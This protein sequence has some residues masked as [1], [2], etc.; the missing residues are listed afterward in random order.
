M[1]FTYP[2][3]AAHENWMHDC[4]SVMTRNALQETNEAVPEV[5]WE[6]CIPD[7][8]KGRLRGRRG[9][10]ERYFSFRTAAIALS[11]A[12]RE[13]AVSMWNTQNLFP[14]LF[15]IQTDCVSCKELPDS[16]NEFIIKTKNL[17]SFGFELLTDLGIRDGQ[18]DLVYDTEHGDICP[19]CGLEFF[20]APKV[21]RPDL[22]HFLAI[23]LY[24]FAGVNLLNLIPMGRDCNRIH[25]R[26]LDVLNCDQGNR[27]PVLNPY[28]ETSLSVSILNS[29]FFAG[30]EETIKPQWEIDVGN[31]AVSSTWNEVWNIKER[32]SASVFTRSYV[33]WLDD[34]GKWCLEANTV[35]GTDEELIDSM[36]RYNRTLEYSGFA[37]RAF[38]RKAFFDLV[39]SLTE[40]PNYRERTFLLLRNTLL[41]FT[42]HLIACDV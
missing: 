4:L 6:D 10:R 25:K 36:D 24:P 1:L 26:A 12:D 42:N 22:D 28:G 32:Y 7:P 21:S 20:E 15:E 34:F 35:T 37:D 14:D 18:F 31:D 3:E 13:I 38:L 30:D 9:L 33:R 40:N 17:F 5:E 19:F 2:I 23:S 41:K 27:R 29:S 39:K 16:L 11:Q 8:Y